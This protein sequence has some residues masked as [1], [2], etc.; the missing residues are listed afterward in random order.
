MLIEQRAFKVSTEEHVMTYVG[1]TS[2]PILSNMCVFLLYKFTIKAGI[3][4]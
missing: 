1:L 3:I 4:E 2:V